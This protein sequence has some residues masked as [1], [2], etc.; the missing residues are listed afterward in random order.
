MSIDFHDPKNKTS[1]TE[2]TVDNAWMKLVKS[3]V[4]LQSIQAAD[5]GCGG[6]I[7]SKALIE[8]GVGAVV[9]IDFSQAMLEGA[10]A[11]TAR[12]T[13]IRYQQGKA[14]HTGLDNASVELVLERALIHHLSSDELVGCMKEA[15]RILKSEGVL[16]VQDR[17]PED[18]AIA[19]SRKHLRGY[20]FDKFPRLLPEESGRRYSSNQVLAALRTAGFNQLKE[21]P[22]WET[23]RQ[24][25]HFAEFREDLLLRSGRSILHELTDVEL[26]HL[27]AYIEQQLAVEDLEALNEPLV[28]QD[29][30]TLWFARKD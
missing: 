13:N 22:L 17:T 4:R 7:Y 14:L 23:R 26:E 3:E 5:I 15:N 9:G 20:I 8:M 2:R 12:H 18:C 10:A 25:T 16:I 1:Y 11:Y 19:G 30:W 28:E 29:R 24:Y 21:I 27:I 6:G